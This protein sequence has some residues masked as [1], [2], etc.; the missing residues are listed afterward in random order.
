MWQSGRED[1]A[2]ELYRGAGPS[3]LRMHAGGLA[4]P[5]QKPRGAPVCGPTVAGS[6]NHSINIEPLKLT[7][8][9]W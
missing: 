8:L 9:R 4:T 3:L 6:L 7:I 1:E 2:D 5:A